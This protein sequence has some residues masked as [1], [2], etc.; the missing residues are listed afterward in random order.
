MNEVNAARREGI[1]VFVIGL[2]ISVNRNRIAA[3]ASSP[4]SEHTYYI[5]DVENV[6]DVIDNVVDYLCA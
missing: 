1:Q 6:H 2:G 5:N 3:M 4:S